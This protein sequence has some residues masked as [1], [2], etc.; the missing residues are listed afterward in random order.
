MNPVAPVT[1]NLPRKGSEDMRH[2]LINSNDDPASVQALDLVQAPGE[3]RCQSVDQRWFP[4]GI[5]SNRKRL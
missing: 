3:I 2:R 4:C 1:R 5:F